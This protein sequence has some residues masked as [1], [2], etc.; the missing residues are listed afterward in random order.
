MLI[1]QERVFLP[2]TFHFPPKFRQSGHFR[3]HVLHNHSVLFL[4]SQTPLQ[5]LQMDSTNKRDQVSNKRQFHDAKYKFDFFWFFY[6]RLGTEVL[7]SS[8]LSAPNFIEIE[9]ELPLSWVHSLCWWNEM[10][11]GFGISDWRPG[12][13]YQHQM[14]KQHSTFVFFLKESIR[15]NSKGFR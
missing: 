12:T 8:S 15:E 1:P 14:Q 7:T 3:F 10:T 2:Q 5:L 6:Y 11:G 4:K 13:S 9:T